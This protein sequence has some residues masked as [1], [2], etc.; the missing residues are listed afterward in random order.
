MAWD[1]DPRARRW[2]R[3]VQD[4]LPDKI[5]GSAI[6]ASLYPRGDP[7]AKYAVELGMSILLD[8]PIVLVVPPG[9]RV[10]D[11]LVRV[12]DSIIEADPT[13]PDSAE[14]V[15]RAVQAEMDRLGLSDGAGD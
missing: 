12:A 11:H 15:G 13:A 4:E 6:V 10:P 14:R 7:D 8:K 2:L 9:T 3:H 5:K 1:D